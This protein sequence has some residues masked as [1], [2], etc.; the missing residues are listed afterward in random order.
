MLVFF[1][2]TK[3]LFLSRAAGDYTIDAGTAAVVHLALFTDTREEYTSRV[4]KYIPIGGVKD[5]FGG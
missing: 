5:T 2:L 3:L 1:F 4:C